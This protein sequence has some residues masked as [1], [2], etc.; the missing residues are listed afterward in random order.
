MSTSHENLLR[1][2]A[3]RRGFRLEKCRRRD[4]KSVGYGKWRLV[5]PGGVIDVHGALDDI[6]NIDRAEYYLYN[7]PY[8]LTLD[9]IEA[10]LDGKRRNDMPPTPVQEGSDDLFLDW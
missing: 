10:Y 1:R 9:E 8:D 5:G 3:E 2:T 6:E 4:P 7:R